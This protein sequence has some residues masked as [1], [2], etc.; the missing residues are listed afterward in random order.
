MD[1]IIK[2]FDPYIGKNEEKALLQTLRSKFWASGAGAGNVEIFEKKFCQYTK[3][4]DC[5]AVNNGTSALHLALSLL[6]VQNKEVIV[7]SMS[8]V[9]TANAVLYNGGKPVFADVDPDTLC[10][11][12]N[13]IKKSITKKTAAVLPVH[14]GG[15]PCKLDEIDE[16][17]S[18]HHLAL[19][20]DAAHAAGATYKKKRI[21][22]Y[23][24]AVCFSF[25]PVKNLAMPTGG[26]VTLNGKQ[27]S[28]NATA[29]KTRR[30]C[31]ISNRKGAVYDIS[32]LGWNFYMNEFSAA[33]GIVQL[34]KLDSM[35]SKRKKI[36]KRYFD[37]IRLAEKM[38]YV[39]ECSYH[40]YW[41]QVKNR[42]KFMSYMEKNNIQTGIHYLPIHKM[43][44]YNSTKKLP[45][46]EN[47][48]KNIVSI[49]IHPNMTD[50]D[51]TKII[52]LV[53]HYN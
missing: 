22:G 16:I 29:I 10:I 19:V 44:F 21:G 38:P 52:K 30:W 5:V 35:N 24:D 53:N 20:E 41:I 51:V 40:I 14:F 15:M 33:I 28:K 13:S 1:E 7:P 11:D 8:F 34:A 43:S 6:D 9:S 25:H 47:I 27:S 39:T 26:A 18:K 2:L 17:C 48:S 49:P 23:G 50:Y 12:P 45:I 4:K 46:T 37:E 32:E 31:G 42:S 36:A 3:S